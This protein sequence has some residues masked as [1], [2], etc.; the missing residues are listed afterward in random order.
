MPEEQE[1]PAETHLGARK[2]LS[3]V[4]SPSLIVVVVVVVVAAVVVVVVVVAAV[5]VEVVVV[6]V[7]IGKGVGKGVGYENN[8]DAPC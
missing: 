1:T 7:E 6:V 8:K 5:V 4:A 3:Y 2:S